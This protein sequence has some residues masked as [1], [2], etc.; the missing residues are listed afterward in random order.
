MEEIWLK[1]YP[2]YVPT[3]WDPIAPEMSLDQLFLTSC[4]QYHKRPAFTS[5]DTTLTYAKLARHAKHFAAF[6]QHEWQLKKDDRIAIMLPNCLQFPVVFFAAL[7]AGLVVVPVNP[8]YTARELKLQLKDAQVSAMII[9]S[10]MAHKL[11]DVLKEVPIRHVMVTGLGDMLK[12]P[13]SL[14]ISVYLKY[15]KRS[16]DFNINGVVFFKEVLTHRQKLKYTPVSVRAED[17][18]LLQ[19]TG[20]TTGLP[21]G[22]MLTHANLLANVAQTKI[23]IAPVLNTAKHKVALA[24][25]PLYHIFSMTAHHLLLLAIGFESILIA[26]PRHISGIIKI[27]KKRPLVLMT[28]VN[29][30]Y[31]AL[32]CDRHFKHLDFS[33]QKVALSGGMAVQKNTAQQWQALTGK[34]LIEAYGL[35]ESSPAAIINPLELSDYNGAMGLPISG[36]QVKVCDDAGHE[37]ILGQT[38]E[39]YLKGPQITQGYWHKP[40]ETLL[41]LTPEGWL[42]TGDLVKMDALGYV[43]FVDRKKDMLVVSGFN[44]YPTEIED[45]ICTHPGVFDAAV[46]GIPDPITGQRIKCFVVKKDPDLT[47]NQLRDYLHQQLTGY[48]RPQIIEFCDSLPKTNVGK[49]LRRALRGDDENK[50]E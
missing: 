21:K 26:D 27:L 42:K 11:E 19:Y 4:Q 38:G 40:E 18:A 34:P 13:Q 25:L 8:M 49:V 2:P 46:V 29:T 24:P 3:T 39:L 47:E 5:F 31:N 12:F 35:T 50:A 45:V 10:T 15:I 6:F 7:L 37:V 33:Q 17:L 16:P 9:L 36:T 20:G 41:S 1:S 30:L 28:G 43:Y 14:F 32:L 23:W 44:V 48:K 22:V